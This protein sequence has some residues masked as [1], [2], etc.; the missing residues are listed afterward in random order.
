MVEAEIESIK[1]KLKS[2]D[3]DISIIEKK[4]N[5]LEKKIIQMESKLNKNL[6]DESDIENTDS[7]G[8]INIDK[9]LK[10][11]ETMDTDINK[12]INIS[13]S[14]SIENLIDVYLKFKLKLNAIKVKNDNFK[15]SIE[16]L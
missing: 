9:I 5:K 4:V 8:D 13:N 11:L 12:L 15:L 7:D 2:D 6:S 1:N 10:D 16:Y 3:F 14:N